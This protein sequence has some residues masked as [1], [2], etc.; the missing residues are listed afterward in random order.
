V[1]VQEATLRAQAAR[2]RSLADAARQ[3]EHEAAALLEAQANALAAG[4]GS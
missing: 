3:A 1:T 4:F 2:K